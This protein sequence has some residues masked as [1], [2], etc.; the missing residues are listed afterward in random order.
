[1]DTDATF[2][3]E[4]N[5]EDEGLV[6]DSVGRLNRASGRVVNQ[7]MIGSREIMPATRTRPI[8]RS[9]VGSGGWLKGVQKL[10]GYPKGEGY[11]RY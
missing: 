10:L 5:R 6:D 4:G 2:D 1:M 9:V 11:Y 7:G 8:A 3:S